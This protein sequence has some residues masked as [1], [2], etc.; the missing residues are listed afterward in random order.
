MDV[1]QIGS[2]QTL[3]ARLPLLAGADPD[4][5]DELFAH[6]RPVRVRAGDVVIRQGDA[7]DRLYLVRSGRLRVLVEQ[8]DG[9]K[10]VR[11]LGVGAAIGE[12]ALLTGSPRSATVHAVRDGE[13]LELDAGVFHA[14]LER[15]PG[16][17]SRSRERSRS[18]C[19]RAASCSH[20]RCARA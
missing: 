20:R 15:D 10:V 6:L 11:E 9:P 2:V 8:E 17:L 3:L 16:S 4:T 18:S 7:G 5:V 14:L 19:R 1:D 13:L 12:L